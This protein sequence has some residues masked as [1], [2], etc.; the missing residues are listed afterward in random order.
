MARWSSGG[1]MH[2][3]EELTR[4]NWKGRKITMQSILYGQGLLALVQDTE[5]FDERATERWKRCYFDRKRNA[6]MEVAIPLSSELMNTVYARRELYIRY[7]R[8]DEPVIDYVIVIEDIVAELIRSQ[9]RV[10][11]HE[12]AQILLS[13]V[14]Q[15][16]SSIA[17]KHAM[18]GR[19][20]LNDRAV[21]RVNMVVKDE[22]DRVAPDE[23]EWLLESGSQVNLNGDVSL[24]ADM[25]K[26][27]GEEEDRMLDDVNYSA[28]SGV[29]LISP[30]CM[31][32][33]CGF[34]LV[35]SLDQRV[36]SLG[37]S[38]LKLKSVKQNGLFCTKPKRLLRKYVLAVQ[39]D[40]SASMELLHGRLGHASLDTTAKMMKQGIS[41]GF[42]DDELRCFCTDRGIATSIMNAYNPQENTI[43]GRANQTM[44]TSVRAMLAATGLPS[45][46]WREPPLHAVTTANVTPTSALGMNTPH[47]TLHGRPPRNEKLRPRAEMGL[48]LGHASES[49]GYK[50]LNMTT[51]LVTTMRSENAVCYEQFKV[52]GHYLAEQ[53][54]NAFADDD[55]QLEPEVPIA[56]VKTTMTA[57][58][59]TKE[60][61]QDVPALL[62]VSADK[63]LTTS[64]RNRATGDG[65]DHDT[66]SIQ[67]PTTYMKVQASGKREH[68]QV[69]KDE[70]GVMGP[71]RLCTE[72]TAQLQSTFELAA[73]GPVKFLLGVEILIAAGSIQAAFC[74]RAYMQLVLKTFYTETC[75]GRRTPEATSESIAAVLAV[76]PDEYQPYSE[77]MT[78]NHALVFKVAEDMNVNIQC[79]TGADFAND[80]GDR[81]SI[82]GYVTTIYGNTMSY[83]SRKQTIYAQSTTGAEYIAM[84]E[85]TKGLLWMVGLL[86]ELQGKQR[87]PEL[88]SDNM[89]SIYLVSKPGKYRNNK[90]IDNKYHLA[91]FAFSPLI[92]TYAVGAEVFALNN[93]FAAAL[94]YVLLRYA[95]SLRSVDIS[96]SRRVAVLGA[97]VTGL[98]LC[99]QHTIVLFEIPIVC[100]VLFTRR[101]TLIGAELLQISAAFLAGLLPY[102]YMPVTMTLNPQPGS[103]GDVTTLAGFVHHVR[104]GDYG[105]FRLFS[106]TESHEDVWTRLQL[107]AAD[108]TTR[109]VPCHLALPM[110]AVGVLRV[111]WLL[112][113]TYAFYLLVFH[114][115]ANLPLSEGLT[116]GVH[117]RFWQQPNVL[118]FVW[119]GVGFDTIVHVVTS[120]LS[121]TS[122]SSTITSSCS[123]SKQAVVRTALHAACLA[124]VPF[125]IVTWHSLCDQSAALYIRDYARALLDPLPRDAVLIVNFDLQ[126]TSLRYLQQCEQRRVDVTI[127]NLSLMSYGWFASKHGQ[128]P[129]LSFPGSRLVPFGGA[130]DGFT[131]ASFLDAN[132]EPLGVGGSESRRGVFFGG[133]LNSQDR[134]FQRKYVFMPFGLLDEIHRADEAA[135]APQLRLAQWYATQQRVV[136]AVRARLPALPPSELYSDETWEWTIAR[137]YGMKTL[138]WSTYL[139]ERTI[140]DDPQNL[141]LLATAALAMERA[142]QFEPPQFWSAAA[143]LKNLGLAYAQVVR[144][145]SEFAAGASDPFLNAVVGAS[146]PDKTKFKDRASARMLEVWDQWLQLPDAHRD[147]GHAAIESV[148]RRFLPQQQQ[149]HERPPSRK[150]RRKKR[151]PKRSTRATATA[152]AIRTA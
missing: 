72:V 78:K 37:K 87:T 18:R 11:E 59:R 53:L 50:I 109:E 93:L 49:K 73:L 46:L 138:S 77:I 76:A 63:D 22:P 9:D 149:R 107:Y 126:W 3:N 29:N 108:L 17:E 40:V 131:F 15:M 20:D 44:V 56:A 8:E 13:N 39:K 69:K 132:Y 31:Q 81:K 100:W 1:Y 137:D 94:V 116:Y 62:A 26:H 19:A 95:A 52:N 21:R 2:T 120:Q 118:V 7:L 151:K 110:L 10:P 102:V 23:I 145:S 113:F 27:I 71:P 55:H 85:G 74:Q 43:P 24:F 83:G 105:T 36:M 61:E 6:H 28:V 147:P 91:L 129:T 122:S 99:N 5:K 111:G 41:F 114:S 140:A 119:L 38:S 144:S 51:D 65:D 58:L 60:R 134:D 142:V 68:W 30:L 90:H 89:G 88:I 16:Y 66:P 130:S 115:L 84:D 141:T 82:N 80:K 48:L 152:T 124:L 67:I 45:N 135:T 12:V 75:D 70:R 148:V 14:L 25:Q 125:Q 128:Y 86:D 121:S 123:Y 97:F 139:L 104:R 106:T 96:R 143:T 103:W 92:W 101:R 4:Q 35:V 133:R 127:L 64:K 112:L 150:T 34:R 98:A 32:F 47:K 42:V 33:T 146:V 136:A 79:H 117:M 54:A 57:V